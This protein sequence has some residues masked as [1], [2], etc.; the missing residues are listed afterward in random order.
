LAYLLL[1]LWKLSAPTLA[2]PPVLPAPPPFKEFLRLLRSGPGLSVPTDNE[3]DKKFAENIQKLEETLH[4]LGILR[5]EAD[6][7]EMWTKQILPKNSK[8]ASLLTRGQVALSIPQKRR[9]GIS[10]S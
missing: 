2:L 10:N 7:Q 5:A 8:K 6:V 1:Y 4:A 9:T 3:E